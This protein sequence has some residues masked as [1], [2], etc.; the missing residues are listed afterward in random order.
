MINKKIYVKLKELINSGTELCE[1]STRDNIDLGFE[2]VKYF[3]A[4]G[5]KTILA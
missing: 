2:A 1:I 3:S 4:K 5:A